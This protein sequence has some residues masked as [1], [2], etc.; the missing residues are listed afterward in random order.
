MENEVQP[1]EA[2]VE[3]EQADATQAHTADR[4]P[5]SEEE[6]AAERSAEKL[7]G[8]RES[9]SEHEKEMTDIGAHIK[10]EGEID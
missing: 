10:G 6:S 1:D 4:A 8:D 7:A 2:T 5:T 3:A 9:V